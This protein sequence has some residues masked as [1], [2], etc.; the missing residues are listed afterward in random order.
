[1]PIR[2]AGLAV[3]TLLLAS[4]CFAHTVAPPEPGGRS[5]VLV[6]ALVGASSDI[7]P[8]RPGRAP[9]GPGLA[10]YYKQ[11]PAAAFSPRISA[12]SITYGTAGYVYSENGGYFWAPLDL[13]AGTL[14]TGIRL[15]YSDAD[16]TQNLAL[17]LVRYEGET[18]PTST[19]LYSA[20]TSGA[21]GYES[22]WMATGD[23]GE[24]IRDLNPADDTN[25]SYVVLVYLPPSTS[26]AFKGVRLSWQQ[27]IAPAP[28]TA[29]FADVPTDY[30]AFRHIEAL[31]ASGITAGC[32]GG[33]FCP[34]QYLTR[35][36]M[37][38]FLAKTLG[39]Y[40]PD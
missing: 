29:T 20:G 39:L 1:M 5:G 16:A 23:P 8:D 9:D 26:T 15:F 32:G 6:P 2:C 36:Q 24:T 4:L 34:D 3:V 40:W 25:W 37:A 7:A 17:H 30:W 22:L 11:I 14:L 33:S 27:Q 35:A 12:S 13:P 18:T 10:S 19:T 38:V 31:Y 28:A 21:P